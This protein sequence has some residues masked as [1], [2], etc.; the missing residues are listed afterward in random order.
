MEQLT[1]C[2]SKDR[3]HLCA[4]SC[5][6]TYRTQW[7]LWTLTGHWWVW[8]LYTCGVIRIVWV[9]RAV[10]VV[11]V[12]LH[13]SAA[14]PCLSAAIFFFLLQFWKSS[15][16]CCIDTPVEG[17]GE[18]SREPAARPECLSFRALHPWNNPLTWSHGTPHISHFTFMCML[19]SA[20]P[21][22]VIVRLCL[23]LCGYFCFTSCRW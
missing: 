6:C 10:C 4:V 1:F 17:P 23:I 21:S 15:H 2:C 20:K 11:T 19:R 5:V 16:C 13:R 12:V 14:A 3:W 18:E 8:A 22:V 7:H 9:W